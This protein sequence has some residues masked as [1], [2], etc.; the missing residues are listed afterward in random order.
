MFKSFS[1]TQ[2]ANYTALIMF[3]VQL[4]NLNIQESEVSAIVTGVVGIIAVAFS[5]YER[6]KRGDITV[7]GSR[8]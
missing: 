3:I 7:L 2:T 8:K 6:Y 1:K 5:W 4:F